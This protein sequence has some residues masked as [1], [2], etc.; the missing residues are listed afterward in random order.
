MAPTL[1]K[2]HLP[3]PRPEGNNDIYVDDAITTFIDTPANRQRA[4]FSIMTV[5]NTII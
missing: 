2:M 4:P 1:P 3:P 5:A